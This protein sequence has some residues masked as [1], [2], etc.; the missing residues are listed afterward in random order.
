MWFTR[1]TAYESLR[2]ALT[3]SDGHPVTAQSTSVP[4]PPVESEKDMGVERSSWR[5][6]VTPS[7]ITAV[8]L[9]RVSR[10]GHC[11][12]AHSVDLWEAAR[13]ESGGA[14]PT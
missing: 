3:W 2:S 8:E 13:A 5:F 9:T 10:N 4:C 11:N 7:G 12:E 6:T 14:L 1:T